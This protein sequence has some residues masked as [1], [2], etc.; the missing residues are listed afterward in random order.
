ME[1]D[2]VI[3][4]KAQSVEI[5][6]LAGTMGIGPEWVEPYGKDKGKIDIAFLKELAGRPNGKLVLVS[7]TTPTPAGEGKTTTS[8]GLQDGLRR[9][10]KK[11]WLSLREPSLGPVFGLKGGAT[12][13][14]YA[15]VIP[16][17]DINLHFTGDISAVEKAHNLISAAVDNEIYHGKIHLDS[18]RIHWNRVLDMN[19]RSLRTIVAGLGGASNGYPRETGFDI[20]AASE[21]MAILCLAE[22]YRELREMIGRILIGFDINRKPVY[23]EDLQVA[24]A[25]AALLKDAFKPNL[26]QTLE[27]NPVFVHG[28]PF[29]NIAQG[30]NSVTAI[31]MALKLG[32]Y[33]VTEAGFGFDLGAEKFFDIVARKAGFKVDAVVLVTTIRALKHHGGKNLKELGEEDIKALEKG[34]SNLE[35]HLENISLFKTPVVVSINRFDQDTEAELECLKQFLDKRPVSYAINE[36][37]KKGSAGSEDLART[38]V[39]AVEGA[40]TDHKVLYDLD[41]SVEEKIFEVA[42]R[43]YG[44]AKINFTKEAKKDL[45]AIKELGLEKLPVCIAK[46]QKSLSDDPVLLGRP[47]DFLVTVRRIEIARGAGFLIPITGD[48]LRMPG[49][50]VKAAYK[51]ITISDDGHISGLY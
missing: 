18:R 17:E 49:L 24:G 40:D 3:A 28:G 4:G 38:V 32:D 35:K 46:T 23:A 44:A 25:A 19:D 45:A 34:F 2:Q 51:E 36:A 33:A 31:K 13:G 41:L 43:I 50:G 26:V 48:I 1:S 10:G 5:T 39:K 37:W 15:Q 16:M 7:A 6:R 27:H 22:S 20:T 47:K 30:S 11:S 8:I 42:S 9:I 29:A 21:I 12:G 14:G